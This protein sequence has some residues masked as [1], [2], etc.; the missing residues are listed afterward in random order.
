MNPAIHEMLAKYRIITSS[1][2]ENALKE[3]LQEIALLG[4]HRAN[5]FEKAAFYGGTAL[6][7]LHGLPRFS[8]DLDFTLFKPDRGF[9][10][11]PYFSAVKKELSAYGFHVEITSVNKKL[12]S[13]VESA[14]IK[15][16]T[17]VHLLKI[18]SLK[19]FGANAQAGAKLQIKFEV[20]TEP[21]TGFEFEARY[22]LEPTS[23]PVITLKKPDLFA[24]K[25]HALLYRRW[26]SR[27]KGRDFYDYVWYLKN[28]VPARLSYLRE[29]AVQSGHA[30]P[31]DL[32]TGVQLKEAL[33]QRFR[34]V[35][36][37]QA[38]EDALP[39]IKDP[40]ELEVW[41]PEFFSQ[42]TE[43]LEVTG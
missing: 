36:F 9:S 35:D 28:R 30:R 34:K 29:K 13:E 33:L 42:I 7:I 8:E 19:A 15:A 14:F 40:R 37:E 43:R 26:K 3:V 27:V 6:R 17:Q 32:Q 22:L 10:L 31:E 4:L 20:D 41:S 25:L 11:S 5:F 24:G 39:F 2:A 12:K 16:G 23:F 18:D 38:R 1:D 21:A